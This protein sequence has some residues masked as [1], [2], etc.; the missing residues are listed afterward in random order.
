MLHNFSLDLLVGEPPPGDGILTRNVNPNIFSHWEFSKEEAF[1]DIVVGLVFVDRVYDGNVRSFRSSSFRK[2]DN[3]VLLVVPVNE[4]ELLELAAIVTDGDDVAFESLGKLIV[5]K[6]FR[7]VENV[8]EELED[9]SV[10]LAIQVQS[11]LL[12]TLPLFILLLSTLTST[13]QLVLFF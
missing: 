3:S 9:L 12:Q 13:P 6:S 2:D 1:L 4:T 10:V 5:S 7:V 8:F 11:Q